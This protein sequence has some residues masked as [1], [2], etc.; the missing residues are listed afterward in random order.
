MTLRRNDDLR[1]AD[2]DSFIA[3]LKSEGDAA[4]SIYTGSQPASANDA[5]TGTLLA[6]IQIPAPGWNAAASNQATLAA[7][8]S[9]VA[10]AS[11]TAG[12]AR[13][14]SNGDTYRVDG[15]IGT[16][17]TDFIISNATIGAGDDVEMTGAT[18]AN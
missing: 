5:E 17:G 11:G 7:T 12:W 14:R 9:D 4:I 1:N 2:L 18:I 10:G 15:T 13:L 8:V 6:T 3:L 16:S